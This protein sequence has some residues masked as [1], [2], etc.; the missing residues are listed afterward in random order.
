MVSRLAKPSLVPADGNPFRPAKRMASQWLWLRLR[1]RADVCGTAHPPR[2]AGGSL[3]RRSTLRAAQVRCVLGREAGRLVAATGT[4]P[5]PCRRWHQ[6]ERLCRSHRR[7]KE[8]RRL[9][10][11]TG[12]DGPECRRRWPAPRRMRRVGDRRL[13][14]LPLNQPVRPCRRVRIECRWPG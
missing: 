13:P 8:T 14:A 6:G 4:P 11:R 9:L 3:D 12:R 7:G 10:F 1:N 5:M 2:T